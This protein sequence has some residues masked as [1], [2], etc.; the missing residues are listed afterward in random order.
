MIA[1]KEYDLGDAPRCF[2]EFRNFAGE[3]ADPAIEERCHREIGKILHISH[4]QARQ[5]LK[6]FIDERI[7]A[8]DQ[9]VDAWKQKTLA[10]LSRK[11]VRLEA[12]A[13]GEA[14]KRKR[15]SPSRK[16]ELQLKAEAEQIKVLREIADVTGIKAAQKLD[17]QLGV[18]W[19]DIAREANKPE[20]AT[21]AD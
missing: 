6:A 19:A 12:L 17:V 16:V 20:N 8:D 21:D 18:N 5:D 4:E 13:S 9:T 7:A 2:G 10:R 1:I 15:M 11:Y 14:L 3:L